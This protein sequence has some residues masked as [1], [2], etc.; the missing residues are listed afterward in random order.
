[1]EATAAKQR[2][3]IWTVLFIIL[4]RYTKPHKSKGQSNFSSVLELKKKKK[5]N[6]E[7]KECN[8]STIRAVLHRV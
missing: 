7:I 1:M 4:S 5:E 2:T 6:I 8:H 3:T